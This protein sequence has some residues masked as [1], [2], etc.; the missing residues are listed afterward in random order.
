MNVEVLA[1]EQAQ[2]TALITRIAV[3]NADYRSGL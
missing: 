2:Q 3:T 1:L